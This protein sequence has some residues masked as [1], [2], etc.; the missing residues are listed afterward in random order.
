MI[1]VGMT[2]LRF[3][4]VP[5]SDLNRKDFEHAYLRNDPPHT[6]RYLQRRSRST[7]RTRFKAAWGG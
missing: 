6:W 7:S 2:M 3:R 1:L 4:V 5:F